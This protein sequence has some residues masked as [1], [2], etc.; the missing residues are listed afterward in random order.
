MAKNIK[1]INLICILSFYIKEAINLALKTLF[2]QLRQENAK[3]GF[4]N[5]IAVANAA[6]LIRDF[7][8]EEME[9][10]DYEDIDLNSPDAE[11]DFKNQAIDDEEMDKLIEKIPE[12]DIDEASVDAA[13]LSNE[14]SPVDP[15]DYI[16]APLE[17]VMYDID[18]LIPETEEF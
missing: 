3:S 6:A 13:R 8:L 9:K 16:G 11:E 5:I 12:S 18:A 10:T 15:D 2:N 14:N 17:S 7:V 4:G 1:I